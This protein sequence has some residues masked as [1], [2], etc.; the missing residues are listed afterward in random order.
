MRQPRFTYPGAFHLRAE[1]INTGS[2]EGKRLRGELLVRLRDAAGLNF[3]QISEMEPFRGLQ[4]MSLS[5]LY[6]MAKKHLAMKS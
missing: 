3:R 2:L 6:W 1:E 5:H 4:Y